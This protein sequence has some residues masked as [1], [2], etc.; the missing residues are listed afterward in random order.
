MNIQIFYLLTY[1]TQ[2][3]EITKSFHPLFLASSKPRALIISKNINH[4]G[5]QYW[6]AYNSTMLALNNLIKTY[7]NENKQTSLKINLLR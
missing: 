3:L 1:Y 6:G 4:I 2:F 5:S 7:A